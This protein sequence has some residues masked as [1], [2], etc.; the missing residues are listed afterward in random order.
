HSCHRYK[1]WA[2]I[3]ARALAAKKRG[4]VSV[5]QRSPHSPDFGEQHDIQHFAQVAD[6]SRPTCA[7]LEADNAFN[8]GDMTETPKPEGV[9]NVGQFLTELVQITM[10]MRVTVNL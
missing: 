3:H 5:S 10:R 8:R 9:F 6:P 1:S 2:S 4:W 7:A